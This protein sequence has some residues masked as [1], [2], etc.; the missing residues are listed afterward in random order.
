V[1]VVQCGC[2][3]KVRVSGWV[4]SPGSSL[5]ENH[6]GGR[7]SGSG[8]A[9]S[10]VLSLVLVINFIVFVANNFLSEKQP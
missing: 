4:R 5:Q 6:G 7:L 8:K 1:S 2:E 10:L 9:R 3:D